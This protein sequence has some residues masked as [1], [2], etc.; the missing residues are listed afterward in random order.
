MNAD[1]NDRLT[2][3]K[4]RIQR[5]LALPDLLTPVARLLL[6]EAL[7]VME[8]LTERPSGEGRRNCVD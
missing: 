1:L 2:G 3:L 8:A 7:G 4:A 5:A 6:Y